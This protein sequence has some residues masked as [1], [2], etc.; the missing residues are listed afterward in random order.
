MHANRKGSGFSVGRGLFDRLR[1]C[2]DRLATKT[3][4][5]HHLIACGKP[6]TPAR[7]C[8]WRAMQNDSFLTFVEEEML[9]FSD[10]VA[11]EQQRLA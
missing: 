4:S 1:A 5:M 9:A 2:V 3:K 11:P 7:S 6:E 8:G 10:G